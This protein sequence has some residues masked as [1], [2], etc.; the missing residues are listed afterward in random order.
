[1]A[2]K[3]CDKFITPTV[4][5][6]KSAVTILSCWKCPNGTMLFIFL[7]MSRIYLLKSI[8]Y[9]FSWGANFKFIENNKDDG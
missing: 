9:N 4:R 3:N 6:S 8:E 1:V 7:S 2:S 5:V